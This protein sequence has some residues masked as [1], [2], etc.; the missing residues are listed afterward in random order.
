MDSKEFAVRVITNSDKYATRLKE[1]V[2]DPVRKVSE[3]QPL[4]MF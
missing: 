4:R 1:I 3:E 2:L